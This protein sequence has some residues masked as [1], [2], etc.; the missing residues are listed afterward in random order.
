MSERIFE[1]LPTENGEIVGNEAVKIHA[2][3]SKEELRLILDNGKQAE[4]EQPDIFIERRE[5]CWFVAIHADSG[6]PILFLEFADDGSILMERE[7]AGYPSSQREK[8]I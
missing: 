4:P 2:V 6:D 5:D 1:L 7:P 3:H 8:L